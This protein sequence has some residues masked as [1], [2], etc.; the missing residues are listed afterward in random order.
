MEYIDSEWEK[1]KKPLTGYETK[2]NYYYKSER[3][4]E[5]KINIS[6]R[7]IIDFFDD[8]INL[9]EFPK[10]FKKE[11]QQWAKKYF[12]EL[13][14]ANLDNYNLFNKKLKDLQKKKDNTLNLYCD[15]KISDEDYKR[16]S[17]EFEIE[18]I[19]ITHELNQIMDLDMQILQDTQNLLELL[20]N[21][22]TSR[23]KANYVGKGVILRLILLE[24]I[25]DPKKQLKIQEDELFEHIKM[26][27]LK[28]GGAKRNWT[29]VQG[30]ADLCMTTLPW[31]QK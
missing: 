4:P 27:N 15:W 26:Y 7:S 9:Y 29:A 17:N 21:L 20:F 2:K 23:K 8:K 14:D 18:N 24:L 12:W 11:I 31:H 16:K 19:K 3:V 25:A 30:V 28:Y 22:S 10:E 1:V 5:Q 13:L 6:E